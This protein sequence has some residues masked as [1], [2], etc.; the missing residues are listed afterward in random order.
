MNYTYLFTDTQ[1]EPII[2]KYINMIDDYDFRNLLLSLI[3]DGKRDT[4]I[5]ELKAIDGID[6]PAI[7]EIRVKEFY[8]Y[9]DII[10]RCIDVDG[11]EDVVHNY[12]SRHGEDDEISW[13]WTNPFQIPP[14]ADTEVDSCNIHA[15]SIP[16]DFFSMVN[17]NCDVHISSTV[18]GTGCFYK[19]KF[20]GHSVYIEEGCEVLNSNIFCLADGIDIIYLPS[21]LTHIGYIL[22]GICATGDVHT[23][24][25]YN[26]TVDNFIELI[27][28]S[29]WL[30]SGST[31]KLAEVINVDIICAD[32]VIKK[33]QK[34][35]SNYNMI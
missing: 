28:E 12:L 32:G 4:Y 18:I 5:K 27:K 16:C 24:I 3:D 1:I 8:I 34:F 11:F 31:Y 30:Q 15:A 19:S 9:R 23:K 29:R 20:N 13:T 33:G 10:Q 35:D 21:T 14:F 22:F 25:N 2:D 26:S 17:F 7:S 6:N